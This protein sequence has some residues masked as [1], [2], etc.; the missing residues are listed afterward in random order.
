MLYR[1]LQYLVG[2]PQPGCQLGQGLVGRPQAK[3]R[4]DRGGEQVRVGPSQTPTLQAPV[5]D[6][7]DHLVVGNGRH[8]DHLF[9]GRQQ[10]GPTA[11][12]PD[13]KLSEHHLVP[14]DLVVVEQA[15]QRVGIGLAAGEEPDPHRGVDQ[16]HQAALR[17]RPG[18]SRRRGTSSAATSVPRRARSR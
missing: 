5:P 15:I 10:L 11:A 18:V 13:E 6:E 7:A 12:I 3:V 1:G 4:D 9:V 14:Y 17:L 8:Q 16:H 2:D